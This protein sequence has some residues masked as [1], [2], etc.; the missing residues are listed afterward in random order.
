MSSRATH[1][2]GRHESASARAVHRKISA[3]AQVVTLAHFRRQPGRALLLAFSVSL[4]VSSMVASGTLIDSAVA[5]LEKSWSLGTESIDLR[6]ANGFSGVPDDLLPA[7][8]EVPGVAAASAIVTT[9][10][11]AQIAGRSIRLMLIGIDLVD[12]DRVHGNFSRDRIRVR[13]EADF[14]VRTD[15]VAIPENFARSNG[16]ELGSTIEISHSRG[17]RT[18]YVSGVFEGTEATRMLADAIAVMDLPV[19]QNLL[20]QPG[21]VQAIDVRL[22][23]DADAERVTARLAEIATGVAT[24]TPAGARS[25]EFRSMI[26]NLRLVLNIAGAIAIVIGGL[27]IYHASSMTIS[28]RKPELDMIQALGA[29]RRALTLILACEATIVGAVGAAAGIVFGTLLAW[30][31]S[32]LFDQ[33]ISMLYTPGGVASFTPS[34]KYAIVASVGAI[35]IN[36]LCTL[37]PAREAMRVTSNLAVTSPGRERWRRAQRTAGVGALL[38]AIGMLS[39]LLLRPGIESEML[40]LIVIVGDTLVLAGA[41]L[42]VPVAL[43]ALSPLVKR[44]TLAAAIDG[45]L[46]ACLEELEAIQRGLGAL[47]EAWHSAP[48]TAA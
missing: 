38:F 29:S 14:L 1:R 28:R 37:A 39:P 48:K 36:L 5:S 6:I 22:D 47:T 13:D 19:A 4:G 20:D 32:L 34:L 42:T 9:S 2:S 46:P 25:P 31:M 23:D 15:A 17:R 43:L 30:G 16:L 7:V 35:G 45:Q 10:A 41:G 3:L 44:A 8:R 27:V 24:V 11:R 21:L 26:F 12:Q 40:A 33:T 18:L